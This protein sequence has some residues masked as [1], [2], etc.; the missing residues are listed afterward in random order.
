[1]NKITLISLL[2]II[3]INLYAEYNPYQ[4]KWLTQL[5]QSKPERHFYYKVTMGEGSTYDQAYSRAFAK[6]ILEA[7]WKL[8]VLVESTDDIKTIEKSITDNISVKSQKMNIPLNK[9]C[10]YWEEIYNPH[11]TIRLY[12]LWQVASAGNIEPRFEDFLNCQ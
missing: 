7:K 8:G 4:P 11:K 9:V 1:M 5:P 2:L 12:I 10:D 3:C 6:A